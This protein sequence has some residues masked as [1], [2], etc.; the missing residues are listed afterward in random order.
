MNPCSLD[1]SK[2][3]PWPGPTHQLLA[4]DVRPAGAH[5]PDVWRFEWPRSQ[6]GQSRLM[7]LL[8][9]EQ[10]VSMRLCRIRQS[11]LPLPHSGTGLPDR[12]LPMVRH[13]EAITLIV[14]PVLCK[15]SRSPLR[16]RSRSSNF[17]HARRLQP[18]LVRLQGH[19]GGTRKRSVVGSETRNSSARVSGSLHSEP[20]TSYTPY[21]DQRRLKVPSGAGSDGC[22]KPP[23]SSAQSRVQHVPGEG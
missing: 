23:P 5:H 10:W 14:W 21:R 4:G 2:H 3:G 8:G 15:I 13:P 19:R 7:I 1:A 9:R 20:R 22:R 16:R 18:S 6:S 17:T 12:D 11:A